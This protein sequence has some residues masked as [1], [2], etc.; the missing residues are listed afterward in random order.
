MKL[1]NKVQ[2][3]SRDF[4]GISPKEPWFSAY[5]WYKMFISNEQ[6]LDTRVLVSLLGS[7]RMNCCL[8][9]FSNLVFLD[10]SMESLS[11]PTKW[12]SKYTCGIFDHTMNPEF[13]L[14]Y[15]INLGSGG[16]VSNQLTRGAG[17]M[18]R[19]THRKERV[20]LEN[21]SCKQ[22]ERD[23]EKLQDRWRIWWSLYMGSVVRLDETW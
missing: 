15:K 14:N 4:K 18:E 11:Y 22:E 12:Y 9:W 16:R 6:Q 19:E 5:S 21:C 7:S 2:F 1:L 17:N 10:V 23:Q 8:V 3:S 13:V 20:R